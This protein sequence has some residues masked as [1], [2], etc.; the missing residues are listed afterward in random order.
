MKKSYP[1]GVWLLDFHS[2]ERKGYNFLIAMK[3]VLFGCQIG[4]YYFFIASHKMT[5]TFQ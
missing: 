2:Q 4:G 1:N 5:I 3:N